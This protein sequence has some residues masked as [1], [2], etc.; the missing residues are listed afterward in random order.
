MKF[1]E[2]RLK[3]FAAP[4][5]ETEDQKCKN[6]IGMIRDALKNIGFSEDGKNIEK[7]YLDTYSYSLEMKN[8]TKNRR[9]KLFVKGSYANNTNVRT[10]SDVDIAVVL[11]STFKVK[12][13]PTISDSSYGFFDSAE[14][15]QTFKDE[16]EIALRDKFGRDVERKNKSIKVHGNTYRVDA[17]SVPSM[18]HRDYSGDYVSNPNNYLGGIYIH[19]DDGHTIINYPE[20]HIKNGREKNNQTKTYY[21]K[22]V[23][24]IKKMRFIMKDNSYESANNVSSFGLESLLWNLPDEVF[25]KYSIYR[26]AFGEITDYLQKNNINLNYSQNIFKL[27][28]NAYLISFFVKWSFT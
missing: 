7:M 17:D 14:N 1:S 12:Y 13:R 15:V 24:I 4:L 3:F 20:Q 16:I 10:E 23:R 25:T 28:T 2:E 8:A 11:E 19:S 21:K 27:A 18:R 5:S 22:M 9:V 26:Y 6:A